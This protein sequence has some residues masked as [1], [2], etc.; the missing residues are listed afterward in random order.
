MATAP[1]PRPSIDQRWMAELEAAWRAPSET[2][3][4]D[5]IATSPTTENIRGETIP[6]EAQVNARYGRLLYHLVKKFRPRRI[7]EIGMANGIS[8]AYM[9]LAQSRHVRGDCTHVAIDPFQSDD[10]QGAG[11]HLLRRLQLDRNLRLIEDFS[12]HA[13]PSLEKQGERFDLAF[14]DGNHCLDYTLADVLICDRVLETGGILALDDSMAYGVKLAVP[15][16]DRHRPNLRRLRFDSPLVHWLREH[17]FKRRRITL[18]QKV[19]DDRRGAD[20]V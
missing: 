7:L 12:I 4:L 8:S 6:Q 14:I 11:L 17:V 1:N 5:A 20:G 2:Q 15:Y 9:A 10:W 18:Y 19:D 16:L 3:E 13:V